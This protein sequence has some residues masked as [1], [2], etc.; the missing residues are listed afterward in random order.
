MQINYDKTIKLAGIGLVPWSRLGL[1]KW[2]P[3]F[4][5]ASLYDWDL[6]GQPQ[7]P[8]VYA[9]SDD[10]TELPQLKRLNTAALLQEPSFQNLLQTKLAGY[11]FLTY[12]AVSIPKPLNG[13]KFLMVDHTL[14]NHL[15]NKV[16]FRAMF[17]TSLY[18]PAFSVY[19]RQELQPIQGDFERVMAGRKGV[20]I[21]DEQLSGGKG[22]FFVTNL[23]EYQKALSNLGH[24]SGHLRLVVSDVVAGA[25]ERS[26]QC[27]VT[28]QGVITGPLQR[29]IVGNSLLANLEV[30]EGDKFCGA[31]ILASD[32]DTPL[33]LEATRLA[34]LIGGVLHKKGYRGIFGVDFLLD[35]K[36]EL[37][38][39]E[40]NPRIT[41]VTP[42]LTALYS[43]P[44]DVPFYLFHAL[45]LGGYPYEITD[46]STKFNK[47]GSLLVL[48]SLSNQTV[49]MT[50]LPPSGTYIIKNGVLS[51]VSQNIDL[52]KLKRGEFI[53]QEYM[54]PNMRIKPGGRL[55]TIQI[56]GSAIDEKTDEL[57]NTTTELLSVVRENITTV[58]A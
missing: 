55:L 6:K 48:H 40:I 30:A 1:E 50:K 5:I 17:K 56:Q 57:Y 18:F 13:R 46:S 51:N 31:T 29:Q 15:E 21:Q 32:Q 7:L 53:V 58:N 3:N 35:A 42:L 44:E 11:D 39:L 2:L 8:S 9:L 10:V 47:E 27:C 43:E 37:Y 38:V 14:S 28:S 16:E 19:Y 36:G 41:G 34:K 24:L 12:K 22:T 52:L 49:K 33:H 20:V 26:I 4:A 25:K 54:P 23:A 45:E